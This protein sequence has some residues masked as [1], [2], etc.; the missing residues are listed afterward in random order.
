MRQLFRRKQTLPQAREV[1]QP[2]ALMALSPD[3]FC[4]RAHCMYLLV[5]LPSRS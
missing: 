2:S 4:L 3:T 1:C 5:A